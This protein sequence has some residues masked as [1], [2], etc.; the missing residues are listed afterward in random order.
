MQSVCDMTESFLQDICGS[1]CAD[2]DPIG[3]L[4]GMIHGDGYGIDDYGSLW[5]HSAFGKSEPEYYMFTSD[6]LLYYAVSWYVDELPNGDDFHKP[7]P[8]RDFCDR[9]DAT[10]QI[11]YYCTHPEKRV[12]MESVMAELR[13]TWG[14]DGPR[15]QGSL[16]SDPNVFFISIGI[17]YVNGNRQLGDPNMAELLAYLVKTARGGFGSPTG[18][19]FWSQFYPGDPEVEPTLRRPAFVTMT[20]V[21]PEDTVAA[22]ERVRLREQHREFCDR[23]GSYL[24]ESYGPSNPAKADAAQAALAQLRGV[25]GV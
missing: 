11:G 1:L 7:I 3:T 12:E 4:I 8:C 16:A 22:D 9:M 25:L 2:R 17:P 20:A 24:V 14:V 23:M 13:R 19:T 18:V 6:S 15:E 10:L 5:Q 21:C